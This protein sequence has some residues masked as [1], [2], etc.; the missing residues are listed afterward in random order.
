ME[1]AG[2]RR[3]KGQASVQF[4][5]K[6][7]SGGKLSQLRI[8]GITPSRQCGIGVKMDKYISSTEETV[9]K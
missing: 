3:G 5:A 9:R 1:K 4:Q 6:S 2:Q 8:T 7:H